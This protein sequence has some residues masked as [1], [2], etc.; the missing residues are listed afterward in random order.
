MKAAMVLDA[1]PSNTRSQIVID[2]ASLWSRRRE[3]VPS[4][5]GNAI[6]ATM[7]IAWQAEIGLAEIDERIA[8]TDHNLN[9][10]ASLIPELATKG[11]STTGIEDHLALMRTALHHLRAQR[12]TIVETLDGTEPPP[13]IARATAS[14]RR[15]TTTITTSASVAT[16][17]ARFWRGTYA[18][19]RP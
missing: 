5:R 12:R 3:H 13:R 19:L 15:Q 10:L 1:T 9:Q 7:Q 16:Q 8:D 11:Y 4:N 14:R 2:R 6:E 17:Q 18:W